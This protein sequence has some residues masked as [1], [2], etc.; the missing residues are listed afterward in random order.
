[1]IT[2]PGG[3]TQAGVAGPNSLVFRGRIGG[4]ALTPGSYQLLALPAGGAGRS[5][6]VA[7][8]RILA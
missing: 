4:R 7:R 3:F 8:F 5:Q 2:L 6:Q 1:M